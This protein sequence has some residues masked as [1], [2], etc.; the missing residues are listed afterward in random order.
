ML[1]LSLLKTLTL[2]IFVLPIIHDP[3]HGRVG[4]GCNFNQVDIGL[5]CQG[6][7]VKC[8][9]LDLDN[10]LWGGIV[11][12]D[13]IEGIELGDSD[14]TGAFRS[15]QQYIRE[16]KRRGIKFGFQD[17]EISHSIYFDDP[18]GHKLEITTYELQ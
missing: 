3:A 6:R 12:D 8:V 13:G 15:F 11:G 2:L 16:L 18:D 14:P 5:A 10:T 1:L 17:H 7:A 4:G 9:V